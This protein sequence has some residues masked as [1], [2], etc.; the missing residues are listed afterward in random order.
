M[1]LM[2]LSRPPWRTYDSAL[3]QEARV[4]PNS[5][6]FEMDYSLPKLDSLEANRT[7]I[8]VERA[9]LVR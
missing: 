4:K 1:Y 6:V 7:T 5:R 8:K 3:L 9:G 2:S